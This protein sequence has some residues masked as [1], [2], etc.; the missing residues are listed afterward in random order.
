MLGKPKQVDCVVKEQ[1][2]SD[3]RAVLEVRHGEWLRAR[4]VPLLEEK[5]N[6][7]AGFVLEGQM[8]S[9]YPASHKGN[10]VIVVASV[11]PIPETITPVLEQAA[12]A[13]ASHGL[14]LT[15]NAAGGLPSD[16]TRPPLGFNANE[17]GKASE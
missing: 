9:L 5:L 2:D 10:T 15:W 12:M 17:A 7:Y 16:G 6:A 14:R 3:Y 1:G 11:D 4:A 13:F 8:Q